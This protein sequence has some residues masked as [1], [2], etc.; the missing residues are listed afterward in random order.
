[1]TIFLERRE[2][3]KKKSRKEHS[4]T[5]SA[6]ISLATSIET[7]AVSLKIQYKLNT[8]AESAGK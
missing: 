6:H 8:I 3:E 7:T 1:V 2:I 5:S 4:R